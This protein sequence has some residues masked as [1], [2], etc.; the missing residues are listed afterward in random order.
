MK[1]FVCQTC[2]PETE[3]YYPAPRFHVSS[4]VLLMHLLFTISPKGQL[5]HRLNT[6]LPVSSLEKKFNK[7]EARAHQLNV[8]Q[9]ET[10]ANVKE[11]E[12]GL[13]ELNKQ[14]D[15]KL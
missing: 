2:T 11:M 1:F 5:A 13:N 9:S 15:E 6:F 3:K 4:H 14:V 7:L 8:N 10:S 12:D